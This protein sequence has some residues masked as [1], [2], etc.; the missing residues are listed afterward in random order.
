MLIYFICSMHFQVIMFSSVFLTSY[1]DFFI[2]HLLIPHK[3]TLLV[4]CL[5]RHL[6]LLVSTSRN[7]STL[8]S[9]FT[10]LKTQFMTLEGQFGFVILETDI[11]VQL[12][13]VIIFKF[14]NLIIKFKTNYV[15]V[16]TS[17]FMSF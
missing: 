10:S 15:Y 6:V 12:L 3:A 4:K 16:A 9:C 11:P 13:D 5:I 1:I 8:C 17:S 14:L 7:N 2:N